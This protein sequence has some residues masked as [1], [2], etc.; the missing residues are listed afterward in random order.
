LAAKINAVK[1]IEEREKR[2][3]RRVKSE[4]LRVKS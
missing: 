3:G 1:K 4:E 2:E